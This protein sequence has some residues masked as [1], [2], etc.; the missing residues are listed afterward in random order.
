M[1]TLELTPSKFEAIQAALPGGKG[2]IRVNNRSYLHADLALQRPTGR[3]VSRLVLRITNTLLSGV[4]IRTLGHNAM[5]GLLFPQLDPAK[6]LSQIPIWPKGY[7]LLIANVLGM[8]SIRDAITI[9]AQ[10]FMVL[11]LDSSWQSFE[12]YLGAMTTKYRTRAKKA[13]KLA[14]GCERVDLSD[15]PAEEW[16][17]WAAKLLRQ[18]LKDKTVSL[19]VSLEELLKSFKS[20]LG[21]DFRVYGYRKEG[22]WLGFISAIVDTETVHAMHMGF[23][24]TYAQ[25]SQFYQRSMMDLVE[26]TIL[27][28]RARLNMGRTATEIKST[29]GAQPVENQFVFFAKGLVVRTLLKVYA[30]Y[31][32]RLNPYTLRNPFRQM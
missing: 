17:P 15:V 24:P 1:L 19:P 16:I 20:S 32:H 23:E 27:E 2:W 31:F 5:P 13:L 21:K 8:E 11:E 18:T 12:D 25:H 10:P 30:R 14:E 28:G 4:H 22:E 7:K 29:M 26:L 9:P 6:G 3:Y